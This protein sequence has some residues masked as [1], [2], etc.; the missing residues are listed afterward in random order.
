MAQE[1]DKPD[2]GKDAPE[3][4]P[5][6]V[7]KAKLGKKLAILGIVAAVI[8]IECGAAYWLLSSAGNAS[9][10]AG[11]PAESKNEGKAGEKGEHKAAKHEGK[12]AGEHGADGAKDADEEIEVVLGEFSLTSFQPATNT[13][14]RIEFKLYGTVNGKDKTDF[15][16]ALEENQHRFRDQVLK[17]VRSSEITDLTD[18]GLGLIKRKILEGTNRMIGK[19]ML[20]SVIF[21]DFSFV[22]Q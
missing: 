9:A 3:T 13:T 10:Q 8:G 5:Q 2:N 4:E 22:E 12:G 6:P 11:E 16:A 20:H 19:S 7:K 1:E 15:L 14:L 17:I 21:S 18:A